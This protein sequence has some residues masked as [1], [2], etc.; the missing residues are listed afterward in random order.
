[1]VYAASH[2]RNMIDTGPRDTHP[3]RGPARW[4]IGAGPP[5]GGERMVGLT[6]RQPD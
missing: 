1:M 2:E 4:Q 5:P 6:I 3:G